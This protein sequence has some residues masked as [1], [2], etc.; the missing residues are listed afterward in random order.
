MFFFNYFYIHFDDIQVELFNRVIKHNTDHTY[1]S[2]LNSNKYKYTIAHC[3]D[4]GIQVK[5]ICYY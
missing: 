5:Y 3:S 4:M 2:V 1:V